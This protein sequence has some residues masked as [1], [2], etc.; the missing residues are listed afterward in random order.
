MKVQT[1]Y[2]NIVI[3]NAK[4]NLIKYIKKFQEQETIIFFDKKTYTKYKNILNLDHHLNTI[5]LIDIESKIDVNKYKVYTHSQILILVESFYYHTRTFKYLHDNGLYYNDICSDLLLDLDLLKQDTFELLWSNV[6]KLESNLKKDDINYIIQQN[7]QSYVT[8]FKN[9][10]FINDL[11]TPYNANALIYL[12]TYKDTFGEL[13]K[14]I[15]NLIVFCNRKTN[16]NNFFYGINYLKFFDFINLFIGTT[17]RQLPQESKYININHG[18]IDD[19]GPITQSKNNTDNI[20]HAFHAKKTRHPVNINIVSSKLL[21]NDNSISLGYPKL[22]KFIKYYNENKNNKESN[23]IMIAI[24]TIMWNCEKLTPIIHDSEFIDN[25]LEEFVNYEIIFRPHP[26]E[27]E[28]PYIK[29]YTDKLNKYNNF[30]FDTEKS[31]IEN[32]TYTKVFISD[33]LGSSA[34]TYAFATLKPVIFYIPKHTKYFEDYKHKYY[35]QNLEIVGDVVTTRKDLIQMIHKYISNADYVKQKSV[36]IKKLRDKNILNIHSSEKAIG[37]FIKHFISIEKAN[38]IKRFYFNKFK[39][40]AKTKI[41][42]YFEKFKHKKIAIYG[43]G[44]HFETVLLRLYDFSQLNI[45]CFG[46]SNSNLIGTKVYNLPILAKGSLSNVD[47]IL[48][49][50]KKYEKEIKNDLSSLYPNVHTLY[51]HLNTEIA[52]YLQLETDTTFNNI[53]LNI[54]LL[55]NYLTETE[56]KNI[57]NKNYSSYKKLFDHCKNAVS[58]KYKNKIFYTNEKEKLYSLNQKI[59]LAKI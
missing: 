47:T 56:I 26:A 23:I 32:F 57:I 4:N 39:D 52:L 31:Y 58:Q 42:L 37:L 55:E 50:S 22:D 16:E 3:S 21:A 27:I 11:I 20:E 59:Y 8:L 25:V 34:Y 15:D 17:S 38:K 2:K 19:P 1:F 51:E 24:S 29:N 7:Y 45:V 28:Y 5:T 30:T 33:A 49:S 43:A 40:D 18:I 10:L 35:V 13:S 46:D 48:I 53:W 41:D 12:E 14:N 44:E 54:Q 36:S 9:L 6:I